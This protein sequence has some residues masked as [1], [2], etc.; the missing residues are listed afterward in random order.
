MAIIQVTPEVLNSKANEVRSLRAQH[1]DTMA[2]LRSL[3][4]ALN[5][6]WKGEAQDAFV[7]KFESMQNSFTSFSEMLE[8][9][10]KLMDTAARELQNTDQTLKSTMQS[11]NCAC[12]RIPRRGQCFRRCPLPNIQIF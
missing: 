2:K 3:V 9:Y 8:G 6:T 10:A 12:S 11:F 1:D 7:A 4:L 5:E